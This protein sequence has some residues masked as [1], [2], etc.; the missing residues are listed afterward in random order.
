[1]HR[2]LVNARAVNSRECKACIVAL[3]VVEYVLLGYPRSTLGYTYHV[4]AHVCDEP[5]TLTIMRAQECSQVLQYTHWFLCM[6]DL[7]V[8][9]LL[10]PTIA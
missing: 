2:I 3:A 5:L 6:C 7:C 4:L 8:C 9:V 10:P 1:M